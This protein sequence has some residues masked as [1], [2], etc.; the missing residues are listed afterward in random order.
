MFAALLFALNEHRRSQPD[1]TFRC[2]RREQHISY[3]GKWVVH[4][5]ITHMSL[6]DQ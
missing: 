1:M 4:R 2:P 5:T 6:V 3:S